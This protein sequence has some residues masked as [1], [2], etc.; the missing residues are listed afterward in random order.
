M[1]PDGW[2]RIC[3]D[4]AVEVV[5]PNDTAEELDE[6]LKDYESAGIA[7][8]WV[9]YLKSRSVMIYRGDGSIGRAHETDELSGED[10]IPG[11]RCAVRDL[12]PRQEPVP[13]VPTTPME[14]AGPISPGYESAVTS[15]VLPTKVEW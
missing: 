10:V 11:F 14:R 6:N 13:A 7:L 8:V 12:L 3:P 4:L 9:L 15:F 5:S 1:L 2:I